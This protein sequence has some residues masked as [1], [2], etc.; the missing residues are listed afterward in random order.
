MPTKCDECK[1]E[2]YVIHITHEYKNLCPECYD[3][4]RSKKKKE[5]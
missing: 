2:S 4:V 5:I 1:K 3:K